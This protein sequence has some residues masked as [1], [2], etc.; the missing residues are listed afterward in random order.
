[1]SETRASAEITVEV[2]DLVAIVEIHRPPHNFFDFELIRGLADRYQTIDADPRARA[3]VLCSE[4]SA[5]C[6]GA[7]F[8]ARAQWGEERLENQAGVLYEEAVRLF[9]AKTPVIAAVQGAAVGGGLG[10]ALSADFRVA[11]PQARFSANFVR[12]GLHPGF[13]LTHTLARAIGRANA[14]LMLLTGRR[15]KGEEA[16]AMGLV[17]EL[18]PLAELR[19]RA[20]DLAREIARGAPLSI[21]AIRAS[22]RGDLAERVAAATTEEL[23][24][25]TRLKRTADFAEGV[26][27]MSERRVPQFRGQ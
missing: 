14:E 13:G 16:L 27:A 6:A 18:V 20:I 10:L 12:L 1:M 19:A 4:G 17:Q 21:D 23:A 9:R 7:N 8:A 11:A 24:I 3:I 15:V 5:F 22:Q 2:Q 26:A 25:Q